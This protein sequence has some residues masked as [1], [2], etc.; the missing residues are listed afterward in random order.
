MTHPG[1]VG[2]NGPTLREGSYAGDLVRNLVIGLMAFLTVVDLFAT[3]AILP[4]LA[5]AYGV[6]AATI[7]FAVNA[8]TLGMALG[9]LGVALLGRRID[10]RRGVVVS[11]LLLAIPT[12]LL[13]T[14]PDLMTFAALR[15]LQGICMAAAF[16]LT[17]AYL[18]EACSASA[19]AGA[20]AAYVTGNVA[21]N[22]VGRLVAA[23]LVDHLG[24]V[25]NFIAFAL[26]NLAGAGLAVL[27]LRAPAQTE[28]R[29][30]PARANLA[31]RRLG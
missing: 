16:T 25:S 11:L 18:G 28:R 21:S 20:F 30:G 9:G 6:S 17:L 14:L 29:H 27:V 31:V 1:T 22:L 7:S 23:A 3:Q 10:R 12:A 26:L 8:T 13:G 2:L 4:S 5:Q 24:L 19:A 15:V